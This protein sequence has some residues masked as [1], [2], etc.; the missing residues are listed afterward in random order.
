MCPMDKCLE[1]YKICLL[2]GP[3]PEKVGYGPIVWLANRE[4]ESNPFSG[5]YEPIVRI[6]NEK[7]AKIAGSYLFAG[8]GLIASVL[9]VPFDTINSW[10]ADEFFDHLAQAE[11]LSGRPLEPNAPGD[12]R[13]VG[14]NRRKLRNPNN[15][16]ERAKQA[17]V[18]QQ[19]FTWKR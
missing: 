6:L 17:T 3:K 5:H 7:R 19:E 4:L 14:G 10:D 15:R 12:K 18:D 1:V 13:L 9:H 8:S 11:F 2:E 16:D